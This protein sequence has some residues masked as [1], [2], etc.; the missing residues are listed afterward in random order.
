[1]DAG[2]VDE[3]AGYEPALVPPSLDQLRTMLV[4]GWAEAVDGCVVEPDGIC[5][6][7]CR[8]WLGVLRLI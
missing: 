1:M 8:S 7:G 2:E 3:A 6:H 4:E 5:P